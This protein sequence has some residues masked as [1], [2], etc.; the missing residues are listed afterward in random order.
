MALTGLSLENSFLFFL[1]KFTASSD[2]AS[3]SSQRI[4]K[5]IAAEMK[6]YNLFSSKNIFFQS[7]VE[8]FLSWLFGQG[9]Y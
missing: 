6:A 8:P 4:A 2:D 9:T 3:V 7:V 5:V 1:E